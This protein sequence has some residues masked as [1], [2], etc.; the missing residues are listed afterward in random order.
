MIRHSG[1]SSSI[2]MGAL[3]VHPVCVD[4]LVLEAI[5]EVNVAIVRLV[6]VD[7]ST[8]IAD[9]I[10]SQS[11][12]SNKCWCLIGDSLESNDHSY[13]IEM[14]YEICFIVEMSVIFHWLFMNY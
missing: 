9:Y 6:L 10:P 8:S 7:N 5:V 11:R 4:A 13:S 3:G 14:D 1:V 12:S 2:T